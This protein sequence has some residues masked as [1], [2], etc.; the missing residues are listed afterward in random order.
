MPREILTIDGAKKD[1]AAAWDA[2]YAALERPDANLTQLRMLMKRW[3][4]LDK[5][6][7]VLARLIPPTYTSAPR[8]KR[9][10]DKQL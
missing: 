4:R 6:V 5:R 2:F 7:K 8:R 3:E 10:A 1:A 9:S